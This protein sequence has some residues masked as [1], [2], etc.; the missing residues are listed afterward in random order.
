MQ[1]LKR[2]LGFQSEQE[3]DEKIRY[4]LSSISEKDS[5][6]FISLI[7]LVFVVVV[8]EIERHMIA[9]KLTVHDENK[10][11]AQIKQ[12]RKNKPLVGQYS[13]LEADANSHAQVSVSTYF[14][15]NVALVQ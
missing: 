15:I 13:T 9:K 6:S 11:I 5:S 3:I 14:F 4:T 8:S 7:C 2:D 1:T 10:M 12:L